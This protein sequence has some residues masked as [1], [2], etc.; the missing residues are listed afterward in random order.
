MRPPLAPSHRVLA[1]GCAG[2]RMQDRIDHALRR[3]VERIVIEEIE[4]LRNGGESLFSGQHAGTRQVARGAF[5]DF[6]R[7]VVCQDGEERI[8]GCVG[9]EHRQ[10]FDGP[11]ASLLAG[12]MGVAKQSCQHDVWFDA[13]IAERA[14]PPKRQ[15]TATGIVINLVQKTRDALRR[16]AE[17]AGGEIDFHGCSTNARI[18]GFQGREHEMEKPVGAFEAAA[19]GVVLLANHV[20]RPLVT[21]DGKIEQAFGLL[22]RR[23]V[24]EFLQFSAG[25]SGFG[26]GHKRWGWLNR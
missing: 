19:P 24:A 16:L 12:V 18:L 5:A 3:C 25:C 1:Q 17:I 20:K 23:E 21:V 15:R 8:D 22:L 7:R 14:E 10:A 13:A 2:D 26:I 6:R 11:E 4:Q 9:P